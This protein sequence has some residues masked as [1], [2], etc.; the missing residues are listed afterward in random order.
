METTTTTSLQDRFNDLM[1]A[2]PK[3]RIRNA[4]IELGVSEV[5]LL[6][7]RIGDGVTRLRPEFRALMAEVPKLGRVMALSRNDDAVH[8][9]K[10]EYL[11]PSLSEQH[12]GLFVGADIDLR[13]FWGPWNSAF[14]V[15]EAGKDGPRRSLQFFA[16]DGE[17]VHKVYLLPES[18]VT[19]FE[20]LI[21]GYKN[22]DQTKVQVVKPWPADAAEKPDAEIDGE[23][24]RTEWKAMKDTHDFYGMT[25]KYHVTRTQSLRL[26]PE[27]FTTKL[28]N[29]AMREM[30]TSAAKQQL[31][32]MVFIGNKGMIQ[33]HTGAVT[34]VMDVPEWFNVIDPD[35]NMH[36][37]EGAI[38]ESWVVRKPSV[39]GMVTSIE[40]YDAKGTLVVQFFGKRKPGIPELPEWAALVADIENKLKLA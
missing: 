11:N 1:A 24:F 19:A 22:E 6:V 18:S 3:T 15:I 23:S 7:L 26:A 38:T 2:A 14:A 34:N 30:V 5:E 37:R 9:R 28:S 12:V 16:K 39:D 27:G 33:I 29:N 4:A 25:R 8:E 21:E 10:G 36:V 17:A 31:P 35:F 40:C 13:I 20:G 32:I